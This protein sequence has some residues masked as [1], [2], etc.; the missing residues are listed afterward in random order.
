[1]H[2]VDQD[3]HRLL[4]LLPFAVMTS[5]AMADLVAGPQVGLLALFSLGPGFA[6]VAGSPRRAL[7]VGV[8]AAVLC[9]SASAYDSLDGTRREA[10]ALLAVAGTTGAA[11]LV[12]IFRRRT[13]RELA[14]V[15]LI[16]L[17]AQRVLLRP[18]PTVA[19]RMRIAVSYTSA[20]AA[21]QI[22]GDLY[23][24]VRSPQGTRVLIGDV[25]GK[26]LE[27]VET[28]ALVVG[29]FREAAPE[30]EKLAQVGERLERALN[31]RLEG[32][33]FVTAVLV[34]VDEDHGVSLLNYGH[35]APL[36]VR[37][38][39]TVEYTEPPTFA[40]P[41]GLAELGPEGPSPHTI[42]MVPGD[43]LLLYTDGVSET[44]G[45]D[46]EFY[47]LRDRACLLRESD[48]E[49]ALEAIRRNLSE[50]AHGPLTDDAALLLL[51]YRDD[52]D[53]VS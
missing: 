37:A 6:A 23:E 8:L 28:A 26:G 40:P 20:A 33:E 46:G 52:H 45:D 16:A 18:V 41:L 36:L 43:Q 44:R 14:D 25:Q 47:P 21:A 17:T 24:V 7:V 27:A 19:G 2:S 42:S 50:F 22:G 9:A 31:R 12:G 48:P 32:E 35:P 1:M 13:E 38:D 30:E 3:R 15:R 29:A 49:A 34:E 11:V 5:V 39:G 10:A 4:L 53:V 51:R